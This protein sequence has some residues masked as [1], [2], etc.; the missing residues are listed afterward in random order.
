VIRLVERGRRRSIL[1]AV[2][3]TALVAAMAG[4]GV[5]PAASADSSGL[6]GLA[7]A[8][9]VRVTYN[10]PGY[11]VIETLVDGGGPIAQSKLDTSGS[12]VGFGS[13]PY[14]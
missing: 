13:L 8:Q 6:I 10:V 4:P 5:W 14:P 11:L 3:A 7:T 9:G 12:Y 1:A 2:A